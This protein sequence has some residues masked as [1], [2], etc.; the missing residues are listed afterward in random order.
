M[1]DRF[2]AAIGGVSPPPTPEE[3]AEALW[4]AAFLSPAREPPV[5]GDEPAPDPGATGPRESGPVPTPSPGPPGTGPPA[6]TGAPTTGPA[7][8]HAGLYAGSATEPTPPGGAL[9]TRSPAVPAL[10]GTLEISRALRP[11]RRRA[12]SLYRRR[13]DEEA[14]AAR[15]ADVG[16]WLPHQIPVP[17]RRFDLALLMD[18]SASM[19]VWRQTATELRRLLERLGA[20]R[21]IRVWR[22]DADQPHDPPLLAGQAAHGPVTRR[23]PR[24]LLDP[25][26]RRIVL[27][28]SDCLGAAWASGAM[29]GRREL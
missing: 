21:D 26:G 10:P 20:F 24:E 23:S 11:L 28:F 29:A 6:P 14:T 17:D 9:V 1:I 8:R 22:I 7:P 15:T 19:V 13:L 16:T 12:P 2:V 25:S 27:A 3:L 5:D 4:L 18:T